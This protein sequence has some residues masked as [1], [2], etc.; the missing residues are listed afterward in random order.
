MCLYSQLLNR[1]RFALYLGEWGNPNLYNYDIDLVIQAGQ[2][3]EMEA[4]LIALR[5]AGL[6]V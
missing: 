1:E 5:E 2:E 6:I 3:A 4:R